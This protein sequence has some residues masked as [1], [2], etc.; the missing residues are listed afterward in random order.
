MEE[1]MATQ[2]TV[3]TLLDEIQRALTDADRA[4]PQV[5]SSLKSLDPYLNLKF[6][7]SLHSDVGKKAFQDFK[8]KVLDYLTHQERLKGAYQDLSIDLQAALGPRGT[9]DVTF[10]ELERQRSILA[11]EI[12]VRQEAGK[13]FTELASV[14]DRIAV[15]QKATPMQQKKI[16]DLVFRLQVLG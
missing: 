10:Q 4:Y 16:E 3:T 15:Q 11:Q 5:I 12:Q 9:Q 6:Q 7:T 8:E 13:I 2:Q 1:R 14:L